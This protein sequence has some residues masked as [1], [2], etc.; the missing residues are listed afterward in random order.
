MTRKLK[1]LVALGVAALVLSGAIAGVALAQGG[2]D[3]ESNGER[4]TFM[5]RVAS[6]LGVTEAELR[7]AF[8]GA[9]QE[10]IDEALAEGRITEERAEQIRERLEEG[11]GFGLRRLHRLFQGFRHLLRSIIN[12]VAETLEMTPREVFQEMK[13][14]QSL[15][16]IGE[17][18]GVPRED[19]EGAILGT[20]EEKLDQAVADGRL[21][22]ER[23]DKIMTRLTDNVDKILDWERGDGLLGRGDIA[24]RGA[25]SRFPV[26]PMQ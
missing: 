14:G 26:Q 10:M 4:Q 11:D 1:M 12:S 18:Q 22:Q 19:L 6:H 21:R 7:D 5:S 8:Q 25:G 13:E 23:A 16:E 24:P 17:A 15:A 2:D 3:S 20:V 9:G